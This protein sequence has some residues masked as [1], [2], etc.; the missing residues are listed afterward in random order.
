MTGRRGGEGVHHHRANPPPQPPSKN[1]RFSFK[2]VGERR[3]GHP[4]W[5]KAQTSRPHPHRTAYEGRRRHQT[6]QPPNT[7][8][9]H[10]PTRP[11]PTPPRLGRAI[12]E[13]KDDRPDDPIV[14]T[15]AHVPYPTRVEKGTIGAVHGQKAGAVWVEYPG[16]TT[17]YEVARHLLFP[18]PKEAKRYREE[19]RLGKKKPKPPPPQTKRLT[20]RTRTLPPNPL[21]PLTPQR[22]PRRR[23]TPLQGPMTREGPHRDPMGRHGHAQHA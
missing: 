21:T 5:Q 18:T 22:D 4:P 7:A 15:V 20:S 2:L 13:R 3:R 16:G 14:A 11:R 17:L 10:P 19:A 12:A 1:G 8:T 23:G 6:H 9:A